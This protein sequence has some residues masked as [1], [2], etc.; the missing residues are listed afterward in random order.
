MKKRAAAPKSKAFESFFDAALAK[1]ENA[2]K[3]AGTTHEA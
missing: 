2:N 1:N 3:K